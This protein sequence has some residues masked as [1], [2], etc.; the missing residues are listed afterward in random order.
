MSGHEKEAGR[1]AN[2]KVHLLLEVNKK[3]EKKFLTFMKIDIHAMT[4]NKTFSSFAI[5]GLE[6]KLLKYCPIKGS[7]K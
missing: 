5:L 4:N 7:F 1:N 6:K 3:V 2:K